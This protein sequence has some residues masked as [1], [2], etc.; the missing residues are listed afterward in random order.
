MIRVGII[1]TGRHGSRY[2]HHIVNDCKGLKLTAIAR[3]SEEGRGQAN[4]WGAEWFADWLE[5][6]ESENVDAVICAVPPVHNIAI[7]RKCSIHGKPLLVEKPLATNPA[8][9]AEIIR[10]MNDTGSKLTVA[11]TLR[12]NPVIDMLRTELLGRGQLYSVY[13]NQR[14]EPSG[15]SW[16]DNPKEAG[17]GISFHTAVHVF[18]ALH[19]IT[20]M[21]IVRLIAMCRTCKTNYCEDIVQ[22]LFE[23]ENGISGVADFSKLSYSRSGRY[24]FVFED[25]QVY[26]DQIQGYVSAVSGNVETELVTYEPVPTIIPLLEDWNLFLNDKGNNPVAPQDGL[27]AIRVSDACLRSSAEQCWVDVG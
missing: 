20:G 25:S 5:L 22:A 10:E 1:G 23:M 4:T 19:Y 18:D 24:E 13:A 7:A 14:L 17:A 16:L 2:A 15:L 21:K 27:Y 11:Q 8:D 9:G 12:Y 3:R 6:I 26:G